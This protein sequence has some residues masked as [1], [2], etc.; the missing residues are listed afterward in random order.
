[1]SDPQNDRL[2]MAADGRERAPREDMMGSYFGNFNL[3]I[4]FL[5]PRDDLLLPT[6]EA[7]S[8]VALAVRQAIGDQLNPKA[9][10]HKI[11][12]YE[13][14]ENTKPAGRIIWFGD[15][16]MT[17]WCKFDLAGPKVDFGW[18]TPFRATAGGDVYPPGYVRILQDKSSG[19]ILVLVTVE[20][21]AAK[22]LKSDPL[23]KRYGILV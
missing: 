6:P 15:V 12:F 7:G 21:P 13:A 20:A 11:A 2:A 10:A 18:G 16:I 3:L 14:A 5:V 22:Y 4:T 19:D 23:L 17:N 1:M 9:V 8:R